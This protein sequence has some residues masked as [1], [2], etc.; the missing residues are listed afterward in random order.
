MPAGLLALV[1]IP[2]GFDGPLWRLMGLGIDW[3][4]AVAQ[5]VAGLPGA[6][7]R[8]V[9]FGTGP[10]LL[11]TLGLLLTCLLRSPL[12]WTGVPVILAAA[13]WASA[14]AVPDVYVGDRGDIVAVRTASG[15]LSVMRATGGDAFPVREWLAADADARAPNDPSLKDGVSCDEIGCIARLGDGSVIALPFA[16]EAF[17]EDCRRAALAVSQRTAPPSCAADTIDRTVWPR[18]GSTAL[19]RSAEGWKRVV[20][21]PPGYDRPWARAMPVRGEGETSSRPAS[22]APRDATPRTEDLAPED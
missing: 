7:G 6:V 4:V 8:I 16:A 11:C 3:M 12:R 22:S 20:A 14:G 17:E 19:Y 9:A 15:A 5:F 13:V 18:T 21:F 1:A 10:L 2:F